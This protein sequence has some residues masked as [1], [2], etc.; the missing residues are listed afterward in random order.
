[1]KIVHHET[2]KQLVTDPT[3]PLG[4]REQTLRRRSSTSSISFPRVDA[5]GR[6]S[7][8]QYVRGPDGT[9]DVPEDVGR[10]FTGGKTPDGA[11]AG[12]AGW[13]AWTGEELAP[14]DDRVT[15]LEAQVAALLAARDVPGKGRRDPARA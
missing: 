6:E 7:D 2:V 14:G 3:A 9:F 5:K 11:A 4:V 15:R 1:M 12:F 13:S 10:H 8:E